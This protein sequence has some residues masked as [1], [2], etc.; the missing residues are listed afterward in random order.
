MLKNTDVSAKLG[1]RYFVSKFADLKD[2]NKETL[3]FILELLYWWPL[4]TLQQDKRKLLVWDSVP[5]P[6][7]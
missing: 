4:L 6:L 2:K 1:K 7:P 3:N 5:S